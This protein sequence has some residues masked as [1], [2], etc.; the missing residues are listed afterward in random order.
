M[1]RCESRLHTDRTPNGLYRAGEVDQE[2]VAGSLNESTVVLLDLGLNHV[3]PQ[4]P[5][6]SEGPFFVLPHQLR[7]PDHISGKDRCQSPLSS[8]CCLHELGLGLLYQTT[9]CARAQSP[10]RWCGGRVEDHP[11]TI[12]TALSLMNFIDRPSTPP[13]R[14]GAAHPERQL[15][16]VE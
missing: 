4:R 13:P 1:G 9:R 12:F 16:H 3:A 7:E 2:A 10:S 11:E 6:P 15:R 8:A 14:R 5:D